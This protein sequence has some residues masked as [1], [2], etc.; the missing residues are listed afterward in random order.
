MLNMEEIDFDLDRCKKVL[1]ENDYMEVVIAI[2]E[3]QDKYKDKIESMSKIESNNVWNYSK[4]DLEKIETCLIEYKN[5]I[6]EKEKRK[7]INEKLDDLKEYIKDANMLNKG[8][9]EDVV[10]FIEEVKDKDATS[11]EKYDELKACFDLL[12]NMD[13][14]IGCMVL[15][16]IIL[17]TK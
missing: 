10:K 17:V 6:M 8:C 12:K 1:M 16:L 3:L 14:Q 5:H 4:K 7:S 11:D 9:I 13:R 2:E 15:E